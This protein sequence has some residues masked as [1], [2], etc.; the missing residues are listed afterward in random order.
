MSEHDISRINQELATL[1]KRV[2][3][4]EARHRPRV[5]APREPEPQ[6]TVTVV[7]PRLAAANRPTD[8]EV[9]QLLDLFWRAYPVLKPRELLNA[10]LREE[11]L[12]EFRSEFK[13]ALNYMSF[14]RRTA[15]PD[16]RYAAS[17]WTDGVPGGTTLGPFVAAAVVCGVPYA[18]LDR[19]P[20][21]LAFGL[22]LGTTDRP[23]FAW[24][25][26]LAAGK[27]PKPAGVERLYA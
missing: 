25:E 17:Y 13:N 4:L 1:A 26:T 8:D 21:D 16:T 22:A 27:V 18:P 14:A 9:T 24:R 2:D 6:V 19:C 12:D 20:Y 15:T 23:S 10:R 5:T 3:A 7:R 11:R